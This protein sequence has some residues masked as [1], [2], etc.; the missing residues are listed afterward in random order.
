[1]GSKSALLVIFFLICSGNCLKCYTCKEGASFDPCDAG[2]QGEIKEC[3]IG[4]AYCEI[5]YLYKKEENQEE[6]LQL[7]D[8]GQNFS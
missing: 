7:K 2:Q 4:E 6:D 3:G 5:T 8:T 1:M